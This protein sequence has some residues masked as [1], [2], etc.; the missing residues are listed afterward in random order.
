[1]RLRPGHS[2]AATTLH[3][4]HELHVLRLLPPALAPRPQPCQARRR[5]LQRRCPC[6]GC[7][8]PARQHRAVWT[9][10]DNCSTIPVTCTLALAQHNKLTRSNCRSARMGPWKS[11]KTITDVEPHLHQDV[12]VVVEH[13]VHVGVVGAQ[14]VHRLLHGK[15]NAAS[16][17]EEAEGKVAHRQKER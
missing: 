7:H 14:S 10:G 5:C 12:T 16:Q 1:M 8:Q 15:T 11:M 17:P 6:P 9:T 2:R 3:V 13:G 4:Q